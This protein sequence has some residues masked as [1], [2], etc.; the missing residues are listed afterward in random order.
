[1]KKNLFLLITLACFIFTNMAHA[2]VFSQINNALYTID[3]AQNTGN[4]L[5]DTIPDSSKNQNQQQNSSNQYQ[6]QYNPNQTNYLP[7]TQYNYNQYQNQGYSQNP[8]GSY[9]INATT[10]GTQQAQPQIQYNQHNPQNDFRYKGNAQTVGDLPLGTIVMDPNSMW[11]YIKDKNYAGAIQF[12][13]PVFW[14]VVG[15]DVYAKDSSLLF[16]RHQVAQYPFN[17]ENK[18]LT[19]YPDSDIRRWLR[20]TFYKH[21]SPEF[22]NAIVEVT[23]ENQDLKGNLVK[24]NENV[25]LLS[26]VE[27]VLSDRK[28]NGNGLEY[29]YLPQELTCKSLSKLYNEKLIEIEAPSYWTRTINSPKAISAGF[30]YDAFVVNRNGV[31]DTWP[32]DFNYSVRPAVNI[33]STTKVTGPYAMDLNG[34]QLIYYTLIF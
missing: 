26:I 2:D 16:A 9:N 32:A 23:V 3:R 19:P 11:N 22:K 14:S 4:R 25:F 6:Q 28:N 33:K 18:S 12:R 13:M 34:K 31:I 10:Y 29:E 8:N 21:L 17:H 7:A 20:T 24:S 5:K 30:K 1:M 27:L 15:Y